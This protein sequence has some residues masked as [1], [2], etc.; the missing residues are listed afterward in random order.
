MRSQGCQR[1]ASVLFNFVFGPVGALLP[2]PPLLELAHK[3][4]HY[5]PAG[6]GS[7]C[8]GLSNQDG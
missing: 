1:R 8:H 5:R 6:F 3:L 7:N 2:R 4:T